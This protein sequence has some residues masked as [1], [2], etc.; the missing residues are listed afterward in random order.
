MRRPR[1]HK[2]LEKK[3]EPNAPKVKK[4]FNIIRNAARENTDPD[5]YRTRKPTYW[6]YHKIKQLEKL[7]KTHGKDYKVIAKKMKEFTPH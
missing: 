6:N 7:L 1:F 4:V 3:E 2:F 5:K